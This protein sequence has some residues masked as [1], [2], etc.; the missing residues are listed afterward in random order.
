MFHTF[1]Q[2]NGN[3]NFLVIPLQSYFKIFLLFSEFKL[4]EE[5]S[6]TDG[7]IFITYLHCYHITS[8]ALSHRLSDTW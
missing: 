4:Y 8:L 2:Y 6:L 1:M 3:S 7:L 5:G